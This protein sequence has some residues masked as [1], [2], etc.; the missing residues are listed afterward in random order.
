MP[1]DLDLSSAVCR[2]CGEDKLLTAD[3]TE[4]ARELS[5]FSARHAHRSAFGIDVVVASHDELSEV[6]SIPHQRE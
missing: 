5:N 4:G 1:R 6:E 2:V 3:T